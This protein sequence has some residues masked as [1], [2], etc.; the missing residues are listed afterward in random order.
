[1]FPDA[2]CASPVVSFQNL[3]GFGDKQSTVSIPRSKDFIVQ[4]NVQR[5]SC[6][7][8]QTL[9]FE[10]YLYKYDVDS[11]GK[12]D[13]KSSS[14]LDTKSAEWN[15]QKREL[16]YGKYF[17]NF[18]AAFASQPLITGSVIGFF[19]ITKSSLIAEI[20]GGNKVTRGKGSVITLDASLSRDPDVET[21]D[22]SSMQFTWLCKKRQESFPTGSI[23]SLPVVTASSGPGIGGCF[24]TGVGKLSSSDIKVT[25]ET[26]AMVVGEFY[27]VKLILTKDDREDDFLQEIEIVSGDPPVVT[28]R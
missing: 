12:T 28:I 17:V 13:I 21:G 19:D 1:M 23:A 16:V 22:H 26:S 24:G 25:L 3:L 6:N 10:W 14:L 11:L 27:D 7:S 18:K 15:L 8:S 5:P 2:S 9:L 20:S 4:T